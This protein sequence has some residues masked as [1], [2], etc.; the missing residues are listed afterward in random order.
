MKSIDMTSVI[1]QYEASGAIMYSAT[2]NGDYRATNREGKKLLEIYKILETDKMLADACIPKLLNSTNVVV[3][4]KGAA[5]CLALNRN[6]ETA[7]SVLR[8]IA[9]D[10]SNGIFGFN[11]KMTLEVWKKQGYLLIYQKK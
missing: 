4:I 1:Q 9:D 6:L 5:Y 2:L 8:E 11:A 10:N 7:L 3:R